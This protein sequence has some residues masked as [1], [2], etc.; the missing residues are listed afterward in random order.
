MDSNSS[1]IKKLL[2]LTVAEIVDERLRA[3]IPCLREQLSMPV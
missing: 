2:G 1:E 3:M